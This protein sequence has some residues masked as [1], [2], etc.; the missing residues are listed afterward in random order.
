M[1]RVAMM[2]RRRRMA[3]SFVSF[4]AVIAFLFLACADSAQA[5]IKIGDKAPA[6]VISD[7]IKGEPVDLAKNDGKKLH[8]VEF[9]AT[10]CPPCIFS[11][12]L[13]S[14]LQKKYEKDLTIIG[15]TS[16]D[17]RG[18]NLSSV[19]RFVDQQ[20]EK[21]AYAI[22]FDRAGAMQRDYLDAAR[23]DGIPYAFLVGRNG[24][25]LWHGSPLD[26]RM[27]EVIEQA[28]KGTYSIDTARQQDELQR[29]LTEASMA[30]GSGDIEG[31]RSRLVEI[32]AADP[33]NEMAISG[34]FKIDLIDRGDSAKFRQWASGHISSHFGKHEAM[35]K[36]A[37]L[38]LDNPDLTLRTPDLAMQ[39]AQA[40][41]DA[42]PS[43]A[44]S[45]AVLA[46]AKYHIA[47]L[48]RA[49]DLQTQ[50]VGAAG[51]DVRGGYQKVLDYFTACK[52]LREAASKPPAP[53]PQP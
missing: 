17:D 11:I 34:L 41:F 35:L 33:T 6:L 30:Y 40:A 5:Q 7:W 14:D 2:F 20:G 3:R 10:W 13:L 15:V 23:A 52:G 25:L 37:V 38:L 16:L 26:D 21:M 24:E 44:E 48:D 22:A 51:E 46:L 29:K 49:I 47:D 32:A 39:A 1:T 9:W 27:K 53:A 8:L 31:A 36:M 43:K 19:K 4:V 18:N 28:V 12:P 50:A 42:A 45:M